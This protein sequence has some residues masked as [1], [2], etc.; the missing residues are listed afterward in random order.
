MKLFITLKAQKEL[1][2]LPDPM[3]KNI[4]KKL[5]DLA[6][7]P[8]P[9]NSKKLQGQDN[10]QLRVGSFRAIYTVDVKQKEITILRVADRKTIY[11]N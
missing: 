11:R 2:H 4:I 1:D 10:Y 6:I 5:I 3:A 9:V 7:N 8:Y